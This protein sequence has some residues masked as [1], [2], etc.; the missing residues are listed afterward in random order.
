MSKW[1]G[2][3]VL[4]KAHGKIL[5]SVLDVFAVLKSGPPMR[6]ELT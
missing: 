6:K 5:D 1:I 2:N 4:I 3:A